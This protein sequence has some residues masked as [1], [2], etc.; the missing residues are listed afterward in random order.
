MEHLK[1]NYKFA[2]EVNVQADPGM[3]ES[4]YHR[5]V[6]G[7]QEDIVEPEAA[8]HLGAGVN[9]QLV[10]ENK[11]RKLV[12]AELKIEQLEVLGCILVEGVVFAEAARY[13]FAEQDM[14]HTLVVPFHRSRWQPSCSPKMLGRPELAVED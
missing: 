10:V 5:L 3:V 14:E 7:Y 12:V 13:K 2:V 8:V 4:R 1:Q 9:H 11:Q 6:V